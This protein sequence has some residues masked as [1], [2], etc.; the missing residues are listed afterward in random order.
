MLK[1]FKIISFNQFI[2]L[3]RLIGK[4]NSFAKWMESLYVLIIERTLKSMWI[5]IKCGTLNLRRDKE[6]GRGWIFAVNRTV[7]HIP[8]RLSLFVQVCICIHV[9]VSVYTHWYACMCSLHRLQKAKGRQGMQCRCNV[10]SLVSQCPAVP[11][12]AHEGTPV[13]QYC[14]SRLVVFDGGTCFI[15]V[16]IFC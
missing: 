6:G 16:D 7:D 14:E 9:C 1:N 13:L 4:L 3:F 5:Q 12:D 8:V 2:Y 15:K 11:S 10:E